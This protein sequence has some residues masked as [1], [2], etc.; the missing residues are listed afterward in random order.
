VV[1]FFIAL[2]IDGGSGHMPIDVSRSSLNSNSCACAA[3][4][5]INVVASHTNELPPPHSIISSATVRAQQV[6]IPTIG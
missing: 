6:A 2:V 4:G 5:H 3:S 1:S